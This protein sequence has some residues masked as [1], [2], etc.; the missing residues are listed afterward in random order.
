MSCILINQSLYARVVLDLPLQKKRRK[1]KFIMGL[2][3][4]RFANVIRSVINADPCPDLTKVYSRVIR[5]E[6]SILSSKSKAGD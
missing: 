1:K 4:S 5:E 3:K 2:D 6:Q